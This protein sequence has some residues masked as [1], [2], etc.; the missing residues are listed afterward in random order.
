MRE[1]WET[2]GGG[3]VAAAISVLAVAI[4]LCVGI[5]VLSISKKDTESETVASAPP[6]AA[7]P[8]TT[9]GSGEP[10]SEPTTVPDDQTQRDAVLAAIQSG[11]K[12]ANARGGTSGAAVWIDGWDEPATAGFTGTYRLWSTSKPLTAIGVLDRQ[13]ASDPQVDGAMHD[14]LVKSSNCGQRRMVIELQGLSGGI[15]QAMSAFNGVAL[16]SGITDLTPAQ[17]GPPT[18]TTCDSYLQQHGV[19][20]AQVDTALFGTVEWTT[21]DAASF[22]RNLGAGTYGSSGATVL[23]QLKQPKEMNDDP[24]GE[25][26]V[27]TDLSW[28]AG[29]VFPAGWSPGYKSGWGGWENGEYLA[30]Q[31]VSLDIDGTPVGVAAVFMP[32]IQPSNDAIGEGQ[33]DEAVEDIFEQVKTALNEQLKAG[34]P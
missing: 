16:K 10:V 34:R 3:Y 11:V 12:K 25:E 20:D 6:V 24:G 1:F 23:E 17:Q 32:D 22:G 5:G 7:T 18:D 33:E 14:A 30:G 4:V 31:M 28:G 2:L 8:I 21:A 26:S 9:T 13:T 27:K 29:N 15:P 19:T